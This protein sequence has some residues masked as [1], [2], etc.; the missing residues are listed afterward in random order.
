MP[1]FLLLSTV[2]VHSSIF[3]ISIIH[4]EVII[5]LLLYY[6]CHDYFINIIYIY[7]CFIDSNVINNVLRGCT[8]DIVFFHHPLFFPPIS[9]HTFFYSN[10]CNFVHF[11][12][13]YIVFSFFLLF[14]DDI[15]SQYVIQ[16]QAY[17]SKLMYY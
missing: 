2:H 4:I 6:Y 16:L 13:S 10:R 15:I 8:K 3:S 9:L 11:Y 14:F 7:G 17:D 1:C 12:A 5:V